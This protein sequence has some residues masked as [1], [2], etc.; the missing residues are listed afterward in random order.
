MKQ[1]EKISGKNLCCLIKQLDPIQKE[2]L[3]CYA[4]GMVAQAQIQ[5]SE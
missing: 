2:M 3:L 1:E 5:K 4:S